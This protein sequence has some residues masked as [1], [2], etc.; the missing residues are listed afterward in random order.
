MRLWQDKDAPRSVDHE[1]TKFQNQ[2]G[3]NQCPPSLIP[4]H[5][6]PIGTKDIPCMAHAPN[7]CCRHGGA[8]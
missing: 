1:Y 6:A 4:S 8:V 3:R 2:I 5:H 7:I